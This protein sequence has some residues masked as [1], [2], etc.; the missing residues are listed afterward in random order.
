MNLKETRIKLLPRAAIFIKRNFN[1][2]Q[3]LTKHEMAIRRYHLLA[4]SLLLMF[5][6]FIYYLDQTP[7][8]QIPAFQGS[9]LLG[10]H[11]FHRTLFLIPM[12]YAAIVFRIPGSMLTSLVFLLVI[13]PRGFFISPYPDPVTRPLIFWLVATVVTLLVAFEFNRIDKEK[14]HTR[15]QQ[16]LLE[17]M[18]SQEKEKINLARELH[19]GSLQTLVDISHKIDELCEKPVEEDT[20]S[21]CKQLRGQ[22]DDTIKDMRGFII[23]L[24]P[25]LIEEMGIEAALKWLVETWA[26]ETRIKTDFNA[27]GIPKRL[28]TNLELHLYRITQESLQNVKKHASATQ[29][30]VNFSNNNGYLELKIADNGLGFNVLPW[31]MLM[32]AMKYGLVGIAERARLVGGICN[33]QSLPGTGTTITVIFPH[34]NR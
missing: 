12:I 13:L 9:F 15:L 32:G 21:L 17:T 30:F 6:T 19:D 1:P 33:I 2:K 7:L 4:I 20:K 25:P 11:D 3:A 26:E 27:R 8:A 16:F 10:V 31:D 14:E 5:F 22:V 23:G 18:S 34:E 29:V 28:D 24:R